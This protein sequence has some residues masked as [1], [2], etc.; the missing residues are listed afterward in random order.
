MEPIV[1]VYSFNDAYAELAAVSMTSL[2]HN[3]KRDCHIHIFK[4]SVSDDVMTKILK[5]EEM[6]QN[7]KITVHHIPDKAFVEVADKHYGK[8]T[9]YPLLTPEI[10]S[11]LDKALILEPDTLVC[12]DVSELFD[13]DLGSHP[14]A[15]NFRTSPPG[16]SLPTW[17]CNKST[18]FNAGVLLLNLKY[19]REN[20]SFDM[21]NLVGIVKRIRSLYGIDMWFAQETYLNYIIDHVSVSYLDIKYNFTLSSPNLWRLEMYLFNMETRFIE[22]RNA[23]TNPVIRHY[24]C[25]KPNSKLCKHSLD[26]VLSWWKYRTISPFANQEKDAECLEEI[27]AYRRCSRNSPI[28]YFDYC[29]RYFSSDIPEAI[30]RLKELVDAGKKI[31]IWGIG[32]MGTVFIRLSRI[33]NLMPDVICDMSKCGTKLD[34]MEINSPGILKDMATDSIVVIAIEDPAIWLDVKKKLLNM[35]FPEKHIL[36]LCEPLALGGRRWNEVL[37]SVAL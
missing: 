27:V 10:L 2:L 23:F 24:V 36:T 35:D 1:V 12:R 8:E 15:A 17:F 32:R 4:N 6:Y 30:E 33:M 18:N 21:K 34:G 13:I 20:D 28:S 11:D 3:T 22:L 9:W 37:Q 16:W 14:L 31:A 26:S 19:I 25:D 29:Y 7:A 5:L